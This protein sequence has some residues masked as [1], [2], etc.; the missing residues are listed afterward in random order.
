MEALSF[1]LKVAGSNVNVADTQ[2][3]TPL[4]DALESKHFA[5][6]AMLEEAGGLRASALISCSAGEAALDQKD[7]NK[8]MQVA[9][10]LAATEEKQLLSELNNQLEDINVA[11]GD[12]AGVATTFY[13]VFLQIT[14]KASSHTNT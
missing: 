1:L 9:Q 14:A 12:V 2:G 13:N 4:D 10:M 6:A 3:R 11:M 5:A 7:A 8:K